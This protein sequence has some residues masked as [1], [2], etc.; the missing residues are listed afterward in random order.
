MRGHSWG[1][2]TEK[3]NVSS[4]QELWVSLNF[5]DVHFLWAEATFAWLEVA[6]DFKVDKRCRTRQIKGK[7]LNILR[8]TRFLGVSHKLLIEWPWLHL[9]SKGFIVT[10]LRRGV[11]LRVFVAE[12]KV[13]ALFEEN[14]VRSPFNSLSNDFFNWNWYVTFLYFAFLLTRLCLHEPTVNQNF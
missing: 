9:T 10:A 11:I 14:F 12:F 6:W 8:S 2:L 1:S 3:S 5:F 13:T 4:F 7:L